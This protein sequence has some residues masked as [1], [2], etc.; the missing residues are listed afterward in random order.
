ME[1][2]EG[3]SDR[4]RP[5]QWM[6]VG[7]A[8]GILGYD[9]GKSHGALGI[10][11]GLIM[12]LLLTG[13]CFGIV[14]RLSVAMA[15]EGSNSVP[16][17]C[18]RGSCEGYGKENAPDRYTFLERGR[19]GDGV[20]CACGDRYLLTP[21]TFFG[22]QRMSVAVDDTLH[23]VAQKKVLGRWRWTVDEAVRASL[24][25]RLGASADRPRA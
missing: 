3:D 25:A 8:F 18:L 17:P 7:V 19:S 11:V 2:V 20:R 22:A 5:W 1:R 6:F 4:E 12:G 15:P 9:A 24:C 23:P 21:D 10:A 13:A 16:P 14:R